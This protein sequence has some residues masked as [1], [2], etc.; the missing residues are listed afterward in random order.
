M[1]EG[2]PQ[3]AARFLEV[4]AVLRRDAALAELAALLK[5]FPVYAAPTG[6]ATGSAAVA[7]EATFGA[8]REVS[9]GRATTRVH[10]R[11]AW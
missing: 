1:A 7:Y 6:D 5:A 11:L 8:W 2:Q 3:E 4:L 10:P 9:K